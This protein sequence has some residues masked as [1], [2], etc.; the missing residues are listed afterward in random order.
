MQAQRYRLV[1]VKYANGEVSM[2][3]RPLV[4]K[5]QSSIPPECALAVIKFQALGHSPKMESEG[6]SNDSRRK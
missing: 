4:E 6:S 2:Q 3:N 1:G 5:Q